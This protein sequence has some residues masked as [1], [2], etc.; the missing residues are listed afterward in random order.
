M[1]ETNESMHVSF[2]LRILAFVGG[3][4]KTGTFCLHSDTDSFCFFGWFSSQL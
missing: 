1:M 3:T 4:E 2:F